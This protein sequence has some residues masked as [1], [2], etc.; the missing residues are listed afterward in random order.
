MPPLCIQRRRDMAVCASCGITAVTACRRPTT[1]PIARRVVA[2]M[3]RVRVLAVLR[4][5]GWHCTQ[6]SPVRT[7]E[8]AQCSAVQARPLH[9]APPDVEAQRSPP[10]A[11]ARADWT[12]GQ[13]D[14]TRRTSHSAGSVAQRQTAIAMPT[15][16]G[17]G[18]AV[19]EWSAP[20]P[21][22]PRTTAPT[23]GKA[24]HTAHRENKQANNDA[25][26]TH[27]PHCA[28]VRCHARLLLPA[29]AAPAT[30]DAQRHSSV[31]LVALLQVLLC[32]SLLPHCSAHTRAAHHRAQRHSEVGGTRRRST[33][34]ARPRSPHRSSLLAPAA[35]A[36]SASSAAAGSGAA[37][38]LSHLMRRSV[39]SSS[40]LE[41][42][43]PQPQG[44]AATK[45]TNTTAAEGVDAY[46]LA[47]LPWWQS[48][49]AACMHAPCD[50]VMQGELLSYLLDLEHVMLDQPAGVER[51]ACILA[52]VQSLL[53]HMPQLLLAPAALHSTATLLLVAF[54]QMHTRH[55][56]TVCGSV[57]G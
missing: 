54:A 46:L 49:C 26:G 32:S 29:P 18:Q 25:S 14:A 1:L 5:G 31:G 36:S 56:G 40:A 16:S 9:R 24:R 34:A 45:E 15:H 47:A 21:S 48:V 44:G 51:R 3:S 22:S 27:P 10:I 35:P 43:D 37:Q 30:C 17:N 52:F 19:R 55:D 13:C 38:L 23:R 4:S 41:L 53:P 33:A 28:P 11:N 12:F 42:D 57:T 2:C 50:V 20:P 7:R 8:S 6:R 39:R